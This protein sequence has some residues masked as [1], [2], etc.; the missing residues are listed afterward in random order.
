M[1]EDEKDQSRLVEELRRLWAQGTPPSA[2]LRTL[3]SR[4][5]RGGPIIMLMHKAF[6]LSLSK[7]NA[8]TAWFS[9]E[10]DERVDRH[11]VPHMPDPSTLGSADDPKQGS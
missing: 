2:L 9:H 1:S 8:I 10:D 6:D 11:L 5:M 4:G 3:M 7:A